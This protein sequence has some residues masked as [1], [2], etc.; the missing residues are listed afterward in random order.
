MINKDTMSVIQDSIIGGAS[1]GGTLEVIE[2]IQFIDDST[3][4]TIL[5]VIVSIFSAFIVPALR[6][7][8]KR[9]KIKRDARKARLNHYNTKID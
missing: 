6:T 2:D 1:A 3:E 4:N 7:W 5:K 8:L 9:R